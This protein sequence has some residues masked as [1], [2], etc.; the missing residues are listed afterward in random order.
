VEKK[1]QTDEGESKSGL[2]GYDG[3]ESEV[4]NGTDSKRHWSVAWAAV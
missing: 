1:F 2:T 4:E 3:Y